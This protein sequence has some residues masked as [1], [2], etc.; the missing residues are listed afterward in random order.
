MRFNPYL[1]ILAF[2]FLSCFSTLNAETYHILYVKGEILLKK[3]RSLLKTGMKIRAE[4]Q[5]IF[6]NREA[7]AI[8][9]SNLSGRFVLALN[10]PPQT[11]ELIAF[12]K[13]VVSPL[14]TN[15]T[16]STRGTPQVVRDL[17][18]YFGKDTFFIIGNKLTFEADRS[19]FKINDNQY[20]Q[21]QYKLGDSLVK[22][23]L[24]SANNLV[25]LDMPAL[26]QDQ[27]GK[28]LLPAEVEICWFVHK[29]R[30]MEPKT[31]FQP[32]VISEDELK[33]QYAEL[34]KLIENQQLNPEDYRNYILSYFRDVYGQTDENALESWVEENFKK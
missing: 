28:F 8:V 18:D 33:P 12:V 15:A 4:D 5:L 16:L 13:E 1:I 14:K 24:E 30:S 7:K 2:Y 17:A 20:F 9:M 3:D 29:P 10:K 34:L 27:E 26:F 6:K 32:V 25:S 21:I 23:K 22:K 11:A 31:S 19:K